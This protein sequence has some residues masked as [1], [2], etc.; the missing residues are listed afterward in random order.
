MVVLLALSLVLVTGF[1]GQ[2]SLAQQAVAGFGGFMFGIIASNW[3][4]PFPLSL[5]VAG[6]V[7]APLGVLIGLPALRTR[8]IHLAVLTLAAGVALEAFLFKSNDFTGGAN[9]RRIPPGSLFGIDL[10]IRSAHAQDFPRPAFGVF[11]LVLV[12]LA[13]LAVAALRRA[14]IGQQMLAMRAN[15]RAAIAAGVNVRS[16]KLF[17]FGASAFIAGVAGAVIGLSTG[18]LAGNQFAVFTSLVLIA[19][20]YIG[21]IARVSGAVVAG[22]LLAPQGLGLTLLDQWFG[23]GKY[24][25]VIGGVGLI[26]TSIVQPDGVAATFEG[27]VQRLRR[28]FQASPRAVRPVAAKEAAS[29]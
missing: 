27:G 17:S 5:L 6:A 13:G 7:S 9:G 29:P 18:N 26:I 24:A 22:V 1:A 28:A 14:R 2:I 3:G 8:G 15:E 10:N 20:V 11:V 23:L 12:I 25:L 21:G 16:V 19:L 4:V